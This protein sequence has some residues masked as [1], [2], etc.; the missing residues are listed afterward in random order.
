MPSKTKENNCYLWLILYILFR[1]WFPLSKLIS[2]KTTTPKKLVSLAN[3][4]QH[5]AQK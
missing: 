5:V 3:Q 2:P 1:K 4:K